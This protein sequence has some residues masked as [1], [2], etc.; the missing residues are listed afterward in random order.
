MNNFSVSI[1]TPL[2]NLSLE[3]INYLR[4]PGLDGAFGVLP[5]HQD[6]IF[7]LDVGEIKVIKNGESEYFST[8]GGFAEIISNKIK[9]LVESVELSSEIDFERAS[10]ALSRAKKRKI[11]SESNFDQVRVDAS[12]SRAMNRLKVSKR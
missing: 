1:V 4:C 8:S 10:S 3:N 11:K 6:G 2:K 5:N 9:L 12:I 7:A